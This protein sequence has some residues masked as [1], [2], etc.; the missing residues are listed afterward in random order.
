MKLKIYILL[1]LLSF[2]F[3]SLKAQPDSTDCSNSFNP[4]WA[5]SLGS[6]T[7]DEVLG[8]ASDN[9]GNIVIVG[10][11]HESLNFQSQ[12]LVSNGG[13][14]FFIA[15]LDNAGNLMW[16][17]SGGGAEDD[18][19]KAVSIDSQGK[20]NVIGNFRGVANIGENQ[21]NSNGESDIFIIQY[22][23]N[24]DYL[25]GK[26]LS[27]FYED[28]GNDICVDSD[29]NI[30]VIGYY[31]QF[32]GIGNSTL[33]SKGGKDF[34]LAKYD[35]N[36]NF[37]WRINHGSSQNDI[38]TSI[39]CDQDNNIFIGGEFS[40]TINFGSFNLSANG[41]LNT[42]IAKYDKT[43]AFKWAKAFGSTDNTANLASV[44][45][46][47]YG[48]VY[49]SY[50]SEQNNDMAK[51]HKFNSEGIEVLN[52]SFGGTGN[53]IPNDIKVDNGQNIYV[54]GMFNG[55]TNFG[56]GNVTANANLDC[57]LTK[58]DNNG[59]FKNIEIKGFSD[60]N[61]FNSLCINVLNQ[62][63]VAGFFSNT[64]SFNSEILNSNG[65]EDGLVVKYDLDFG[66]SNIIISSNN[67]NPNDMCIE[68]QTING[69]PPF[70]YYCNN[71]IIPQSVCGLN[72]GNYEIIVVDN[73]NCYIKTNIELQALEGPQIVIPANVDLC[74]F[75]SIILN[76]GNGDFEYLWSTNATN[77]AIEVNEA[78]TYSVTVTDTGSGCSSSAST[79]VTQIPNPDLLPATDS[80]CFGNELTITT[81]DTYT[82]YFWSDGSINQHFTSGNSGEHWVKVY[83]ANTHC[84]Y[85]DT[86]T[87]IYFPKIELN[88]EKNV[89]I[90]DGDS[91]LVSAPEGYVSYQWSDN[92]ISESIWF[93][94]AGTFS[95][96]VTDQHSCTASCEI[97]VSLGESP[98]INLGED[99]SI[100]TN[101]AVVLNANA[102]G[103]NL[104]YLWNDNSS[105]ET[106]T[107]TISGTYWI[108]VS[109]PTG[110]DAIDTIRVDIFPQPS[111][112]LG[113]DIE[114]CYGETYVIEVDS[115]YATYQWS[116]DSTTSSISVN[117][118]QTLFLTV[119]DSNNCTAT[120]KINILEHDLLA[121]FI[122]YDTT[123]CEGNTYIL[124]TDREYFKYKWQNGSNAPTFTVTQP[125]N[126]AL[127][128][129]DE[130]GCSGSTEI[131]VEFLEGP[132]WDSYNA[133]GG[134]IEVFASG[135]AQPYVYSHDGDTWQTS[136]IFT[137]LPTGVYTIS[138]MD[139]NYCLISYEIFLDE[140]L[141]IPNFFTPNGDGFNDTWIITGLYHY[142]DAVVEIFDRF[143]KKLYSSTGANFSWDGTYA[144]RDLPSETYWYVI[145][146]D[147]NKKYV[148]KGDITI[149][150]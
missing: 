136:N 95:L 93:S 6:N 53:V 29:D 130:I 17:E 43:G 75:E 44:E 45:T 77:Q 41:S 113:D 101:E 110:C 63:V 137:N 27:G 124:A 24:G 86:I 98:I 10:Y 23:P 120:D 68:I 56:N 81:F 30:I 72:V 32:L 106:L 96:T 80:L 14:D 20:I 119:T 94:Q 127:T 26:F 76:A 39:A 150:R 54:A 37:L 128:V 19:A 88:L 34:L 102:Q 146:L 58:F 104:T 145:T 33:V 74:P 118:T 73:N 133:G 46:D 105:E 50:K 91:V 117:S 103:E 92:T 134:I 8:V 89:V 3:I 90:C 65:D 112:D 115:T 70:T 31:D 69:T 139:D 71:A 142:P 116:N 148:L 121:P 129:Y 1:F 62:L 55:S 138:I 66:F 78:G 147:S 109:G 143:G 140:S 122:G 97:N 99:F 123:F 84:Y 141:N 47:I 35:K 131:N 9:E 52:K 149:K 57:F 36:G 13:S 114:F 28:S 2:S 38:A 126:Y 132:V 15:K 11:F 21:I 85:Y 25:W 49:V 51:I 59:V 18:I 22:S 144:G 42:F 79:N 108:K 135:G 12:T 87:F 107:I 111:L 4:I 5:K 67:C 16:I 125:G 60:T 82:S 61:S 48:N 100:C 40:G 64:L 83:D 7:I